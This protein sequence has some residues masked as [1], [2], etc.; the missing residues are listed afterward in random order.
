MNQFNRYYKDGKVILPKAMQYYV[1]IGDTKYDRMPVEDKVLDLAFF[2]SHGGNLVKEIKNYLRMYP[3]E[4]KDSIKVR[5]LD[6]IEFLRSGDALHYLKPMEEMPLKDVVNLLE[7]EL[8]ARYIFNDRSGTHRLKQSHVDIATAIKGK[9]REE[10]LYLITHPMTNDI[11]MTFDE[12]QEMNPWRHFIGGPTPLA[13]RREGWQMVYP[14]DKNDIEAYN[15]RN[16]DNTQYQFKLDIPPEPFRGNLIDPKLVI[17]SLNPGYIERLNG[18][19]VTRLNQ[20]SINE[21]INALKDNLNMKKSRIVFNEVDNIIG[22]GYW[23]QMFS[24]IKRDLGDK[25][26]SY[27]GKAALIQYLPYFSEKLNNWS[28]S[29]H[30][31]SQYFTRH[32]I[33]HILY[34]HKECIFLIMRSKN[35]WN[36]LIGEEMEIFKDRFIFG[37]SPRGVQKISKGNLSAENYKRVLG[38]LR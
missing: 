38:V 28:H 7:E 5:L 11:Y 9:T 33:R 19:L 34:E 26:D 8:L 1:C 30:L 15:H 24:D 16:K 13:I 3:N 18:D 25:T 10:N 29:N 6:Y 31:P 4:D 22:D 2:I 32:L 37:E 35:Y 36:T 23:M 17:L 21:F 20:E 27:L 12:L 14:G